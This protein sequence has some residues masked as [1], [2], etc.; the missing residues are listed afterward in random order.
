[1]QDKIEKYLLAVCV[2]EV[3]IKCLPIKYVH[4]QIPNY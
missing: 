4:G 1:M 2:Y 3:Q